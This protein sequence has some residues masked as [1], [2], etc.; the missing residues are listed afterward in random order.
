MSSGVPPRPP[1]TK[2]W[3]TR[4]RSVRRKAA[5][6][7]TSSRTAAM[8][9]TSTPSSAR[10]RASQDALVFSVSP[11]TISFPTVRITALAISPSL[12]E[13][14]RLAGKRRQNLRGDPRRCDRVARAVTEAPVQALHT[15]EVGEG[16]RPRLPSGRQ[17][18][19][20]RPGGRLRVGAPSRGELEAS[21]T[22]LEPAQIA[23]P[24]NDRACV[25]PHA[26]GS[27]RLHSG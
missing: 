26:G 25:S 18:G 23:E 19:L 20:N 13:R 5:I 3:S 22:V 6:W 24:T 11:E 27:E 2:T 17:E 16:G 9:F 14:K 8:S 12:G 4:G 15:V 7:S 10:R 1:V 21:V